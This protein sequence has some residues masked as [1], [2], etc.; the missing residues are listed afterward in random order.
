ML[1]H[2]QASLKDILRQDDSCLLQCLDEHMDML[3]CVGKI[4]DT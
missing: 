3:G 1:E 4:Q 2:M